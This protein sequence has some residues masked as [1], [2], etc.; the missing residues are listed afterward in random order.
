MTV[1]T[2]PA[3]LR[4][5]APLPLPGGVVAG[6]GDAPAP[7]RFAG[8]LPDTAPAVGHASRRRV[9]L[10]VVAVAAAS[11][12]VGAY[13]YTRAPAPPQVTTAAVSRG[14][15]TRTVATTGTVQPVTSVSVGSQVSGTVSWLGADFNTIVQKGQILARLDPSL[16]EA[17][18][19]Q[20]RS[21][22]VKA[23]ADLDRS[24]VTLDDAQMKFSRAKTLA[25]RELLSRSDLDVAALN[26]ASAAATLKGSD[27]QVVQA[28]ASLNQAQVNLDHT[29]ITAPI[30]GTVTQRSVDV[31]Q[32]VAASMSSPTI[33]VIAADLTKMQVNAGIDESDIGQIQPGQAVTFGVDAYPETAFTGVVLQVRLQATIVSN[34]TTYPTIIDVPNPNSRLRPGMTATVKVIV[35]SRP[36]VLRVPNAALRVRPT[37][38]VLAALGTP[39]SAGSTGAKR[40]VGEGQVWT[41]VG[42]R[43]ASVPVRLGITDGSVTELLAPGLAAGTPVVTAIASAPK[44]TAAT[45]GAASSNPLTG[46]GQGQRIR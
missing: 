5:L 29:I 22:V 32:T 42:G 28:Q 26:V 34:V 19:A 30:S 15:V 36:D 7:D 41:F 16:L 37:A 13:Y 18:V 4:V 8:L 21:G 38:E 20:A 17:Q 14:S 24:R 33:F 10:V 25:D 9:A 45:K 43:L 6:G 39:S 23:K 35:A 31:G 2:A 46:A 1:S 3:Q 27:A 44:S 11:V 40:S 12:G